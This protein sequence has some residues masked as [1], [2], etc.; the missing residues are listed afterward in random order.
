[1]EG[2]LNGVRGVQTGEVTDKPSR[3]GLRG[4]GRSVPEGG[5]RWDR[6]GWSKESFVKKFHL[7]KI[8]H[9]SYNIVSIV[10]AMFLLFRFLTS[11]LP[12]VVGVGG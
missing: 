3:S 8:S 4:A 2:V 10:S 7:V 12:G 9:N 1:M 11:S 6:S 5:R